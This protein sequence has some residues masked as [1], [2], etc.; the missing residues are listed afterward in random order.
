M[1]DQQRYETIAALGFPFMLTPNLDSLTK[2]G[3]SFPLCFT[4]GATCIPA[5]AAIFTGMHAHN[6]GCYSFN[7]WSHQPTWVNQLRAAGYYCVNIGKMHIQPIFDSMSFDERIVVENPTSA[8]SAGRDDEWG[9]HLSIAGEIRPFDRHRSDPSWKSRHQGV[10]WHL[11]ERLHSDVFVGDSALGWI[12]RH[13][14]QGPVFLQIGFPGPHE[15]YDPLPRHLAAYAGRD[16]PGPVVRQNEL[17]GKPPQH[18]AHAA[19]NRITDHESTIDFTDATEDEVVEMRRHY[20]A[21]VSAIDEKIG[22][23]LQALESAG[24]LDNALIIFTSDHGDMLGDHGLPYKWLMYDSVVHVPLIVWDTSGRFGQL[25]TEGLVSHVDLGPTVLEAAGVA[26][27]SYLEGQ[28]LLGGRERNA[29]FCEDNY[30]TMVRSERWKYVHYTFEEEVGELYDMQADPHELTNLFGHAE[31]A[32]T[33]EA[34]RSILLRWLTRSTYRTSVARNFAGGA[35]KVWPLMPEDGHFLHP[36]P[37]LLPDSWS[38]LA[39]G[40]QK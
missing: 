7:D 30:L 20:Y 27:P 15:P 32:E 10:P 6:T 12:N 38:V 29:V 22:E 1:T 34:M 3:Q 25:H 28:S 19:F 2:R 9:R 35:N 39:R 23:I 21:K 37:K 24:Y 11:D 4:A 14:R 26:V 36:R 5:R 13:Q 40:E 33:V 18:A 16:L 31:V 8:F 17:A